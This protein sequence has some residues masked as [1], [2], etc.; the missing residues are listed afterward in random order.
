[1][2]VVDKLVEVLFK[3]ITGVPEKYQYTIVYILAG[4]VCTVLSLFIGGV[5]VGLV[6]MFG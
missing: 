2:R 6:G 5:I 1:V 3:E 4:M